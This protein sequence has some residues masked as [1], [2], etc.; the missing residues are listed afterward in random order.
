M[1]YFDQS[2]TTAPD[3]SVL[4]TYITVSKKFFGNPSS[5]HALGEQPEAIL[6]KSTQQ[7][8]NLLGIQEKEVIFTSGAT[9][10]NNMALKGVAYQYK[11]RG[12]HIITTSIEHPSVLKVCE[13]LEKQGFQITY[14]PVDETGRMRIKDLADAIT[15]QTILVSVQH[16]NNEVGSIQPIQE[17]GELLKK[18]PTILFH[19]DG[20]QGIGKVPFNLKESRVDLYSLS[21]HKFHCVKGIGILYVRKGIRLFPLIEGGGQQLQLRGGTENLPAIAAFAKALRIT[22][23]D[24]DT[25][26]EKLKEIQVYLRSALSQMDGVAVHTPIQYAAPHILNIS[27]SDIKPEAVIQELSKHEI[28]ISSRSA[29]SA[30]KSEPSHVLLAMGA[31]QAEARTSLRFSFSFHNT[32]AEATEMMKIVP[33]I[34]QQIQDVMR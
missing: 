31:T 30:K 14:L 5:L 11:N 19:V 6:R 9:E 2:A 28:Y 32:L 7:V 33:N 12:N 34:I 26:I 24:M 20:V 13:Q 16:V 10:S 18:Y 23:D 3:E 17:V 27:V 29:C 8:A 21:G 1:L 15:D 4:E 22:F 25:K